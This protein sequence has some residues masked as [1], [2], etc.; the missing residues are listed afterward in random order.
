MELPF[1]PVDLVAVDPA[2]NIGRRWRIVASRDL[3]GHIIIE[4]LWGRIDARG[5]R[6]ARSFTD[7]PAAACYVRSLLRRRG[8]AA[9]RLG[10]AYRQ[11]WA[12]PNIAPCNVSRCLGV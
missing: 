9:K 8:T 4:T 2:R 11:I 7:E 6:L 3:F 10:V 5:R 1:I 12:S